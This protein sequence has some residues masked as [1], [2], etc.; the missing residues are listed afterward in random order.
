LGRLPRKRRHGSALLE[1][2]DEVLGSVEEP[3]KYNG[4]L[5]DDEFTLLLHYL[6]REP[7]Q[8]GSITKALLEVVWVDFEGSGGIPAAPFRASLRP[9]PAVPTWWPILRRAQRRSRMARSATEGLSSHVATA[10]K[11]SN[12]SVSRLFAPFHLALPLIE[13]RL[14][15]CSSSRTTRQRRPSVG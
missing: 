1:T 7:L 15:T 8:R 9:S 11:G 3:P 6:P 5:T 10:V 14:G 13:V 2:V 12:R 4:D